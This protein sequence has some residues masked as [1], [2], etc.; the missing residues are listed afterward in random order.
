MFW[1]TSDSKFEISMQGSLEQNPSI[2]QYGF[3]RKSRKYVTAG[4]ELEKRLMAQAEAT[5]DILKQNN[6]E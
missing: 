5:G 6:T 3:S 1:I 2:I 4:S